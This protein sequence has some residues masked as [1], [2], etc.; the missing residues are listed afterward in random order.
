MKRIN[1]IYLLIALNIVLI[2]FRDFILPEE[3]TAAISAGVEST[4]T[5]LGPFGYVGIVVVYILCGFFFVPL[6]IPLNVLGGTLY[7]ALTGTV[8]ALV[9]I[10]LATIASVVSVR[11]LFTGMRD[12]IDKRPSLMK[13]ISHADVHSIFVILAVRFSVIVP[14][15]LQNIALAATNISATRITLV[16]A[17]SAIPGAAIYSLLGAGLVEAQQVSELV[18]YVAVPI[19]LMLGLTGAMLYFRNRSQSSSSTNASEL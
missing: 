15:L 5:R 18:L 3:M 7:G 1:P 19:L 8:V 6:L 12:S 11:Y 9:G 13:L 4:L 14:Y 17:F 16:T 2:L 10:T